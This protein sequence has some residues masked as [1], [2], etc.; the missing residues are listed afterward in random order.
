MDD[1]AFVCILQTFADLLPLP[2]HLL[3][4]KGST[5]QSFCKGFALEVLHYQ[6]INTVLVADIVS[7]QMLGWLSED[8][9]FAS[10]SKRSLAS[11]FSDMWAGRTLIA[12]VRSRR[13][14]RPRYTSPMP[15]APSGDWISYGP[16]LVPAVSAIRTRNYID[17]AACRRG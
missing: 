9:A 5:T 4:R 15:P 16:S 12:T 10:R 17:Y 8:I 7:V 3:Q 14:S 1:S 13:V 6:E 11:G 2:E